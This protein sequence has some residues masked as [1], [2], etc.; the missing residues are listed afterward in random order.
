M[1]QTTTISIT[2]LA[3]RFGRFIAAK[4][5]CKTCNVLVRKYKL[6][7]KSCKQKQTTTINQIHVYVLMQAM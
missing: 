2:V 7:K 5:A 1:Q 3:R 6:Q 4:P